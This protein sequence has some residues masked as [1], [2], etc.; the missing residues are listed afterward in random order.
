MAQRAIVIILTP[1]QRTCDL[2]IMN[3]L[4]VRTHLSTIEKDYIG[5]GWAKVDFS[6]C[7][8]VTHVIEKINHNYTD[9]IG[10]HSNSV[11][12]FFNLSKGDIV[13]VP[14]SKAIAIGVV[15]G[16]KSFDI[17][18][19]N[20]KSCNLISVNF[21]RTADGH[22]LRIPRKSVTNGL[23]SRLKARKS[24]TSLLEFK[25][26]INRIVSAIKSKGAYK[27]ET[28]ILEKIA[29]AENVFK[30]NLLMSIK[31]GNTWLSAGGLGLEQLVKELI[32]I[33]GYTASIQAKNQTSDISDI[34]IL[35]HR[36]DRFSESNLMIQVKHHSNTSSNHGLKQLIAFNEFEDNNYQKWFITTAEVS[37]ETL[38]LAQ[39][40]NIKV[41]VGWEFVDWIY[42]NIDS[43][44]QATKHLLGIIETPILL[45]THNKQP[46]K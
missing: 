6:I 21:F 46:K 32:T 12:R 25:D 11:K 4:M 1:T 40:N 28:Y 45:T 31:Q 27:Q 42:E 44:S 17:S 34:D 5:Y 43:L 39:Q 26:E 22:V 20:K 2:I 19:A 18:L 41:M 13:I 36:V 33:E 7:D 16:E 35:A 29:E 8:N 14:L 37:E 9:G 23:E 30:Q 10:R 24:N 38:Y 15:S 3:I